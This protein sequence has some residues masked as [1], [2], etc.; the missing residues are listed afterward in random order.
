VIIGVKL[1]HIRNRMV[2]DFGHLD[3]QVSL[4]S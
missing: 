1:E 3:L 4:P 2:D